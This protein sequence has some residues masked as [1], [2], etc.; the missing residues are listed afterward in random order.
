MLFFLIN[1][2]DRGQLVCEPPCSFINYDCDWNVANI[3]AEWL[4]SSGLVT[5][6]YAYIFINMN[7]KNPDYRW[8]LEDDQINRTKEN[9][10]LN[11]YD[12]AKFIK[13]VGK[14]VIF[15]FS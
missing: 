10:E 7:E 11:A 14:N 15:I 8:Y 5:C 9:D 13:A 3:G 4:S 1:L 6:I 12:K 2:G